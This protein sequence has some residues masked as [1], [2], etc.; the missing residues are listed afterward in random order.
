MVFFAYVFIDFS[1][2]VTRNFGYYDTIRILFGVLG[3]IHNI[4]NLYLLLRGLFNWYLYSL[5]S[6]DL[7]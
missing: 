7:T 2:L 4:K 5:V 1:S 3:N 6:H